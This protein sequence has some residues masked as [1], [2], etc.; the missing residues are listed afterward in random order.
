MQLLATA[1]AA[2]AQP[3][4]GACPCLLPGSGQMCGPALYIPDI[5]YLGTTIG[6]CPCSRARQ[7]RRN[8]AD[9]ECVH[10]HVS[11]GGAGPSSMILEASHPVFSSRDFLTLPLRLPTIPPPVR[12]A[13]LLACLL[14]RSCSCL[15]LLLLFLARSCTVSSIFWPLA[16]F[17]ALPRL[18]RVALA[19]S[20]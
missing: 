17:F 7:G 15:L 3:A 12:L 13:C 10:V 19:G 8:R 14:V 2:A 20:T 16:V 18:L 6:R 5:L 1:T 11:R 9:R 4:A